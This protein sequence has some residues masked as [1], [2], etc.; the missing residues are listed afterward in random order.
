[1]KNKNRYSFPGKIMDLL[2]TDDRFLQDIYKIKKIETS[3]PRYDQWRTE[4]GF[5]MS[6]ALAGYSY[7]DIILK[8]AGRQL[9]I[10]SDGL[11]E[12]TDTENSLSDE[13]SLKK[14][15]EKE[16]M[17]SAD[18]LDFGK[19]VSEATVDEI[20][21]IENEVNP[22]KIVGTDGKVKRLDALDL[23]P[24]KTAFVFD[25]DRLE[26][27]TLFFHMPVNLTID[28]FLIYKTDYITGNHDITLKIDDFSRYNKIKEKLHSDYKKQ[29]SV[30]KGYVSRG[31]ARRSFKV[32]FYISE[33]FDLGKV[34]ANMEHGLLHVFIP[35]QKVEE[36]VVKINGDTNGN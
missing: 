21:K 28:E 3:F 8:I 35:E 10:S 29:A 6:F 19:L 4:E 32:S 18:K 33:E 17:T 16:F 22:T 20:V 31:I 7:D 13:N 27:D 2:L 24:D 26:K 25:K 5:H 1:M 30:H 14:I 36:Y 9:M 23:D 15:I 34:K 12:V 11:L